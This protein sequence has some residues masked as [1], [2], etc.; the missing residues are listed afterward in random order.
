MN[1]SGLLNDSTCTASKNAAESSFILS[2]GHP[3]LFNKPSVSGVEAKTLSLFPR[4][5]A[6]PLDRKASA[7]WNRRIIS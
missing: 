1:S 2:S 6:K 5:Q 4:H 3:A 7:S